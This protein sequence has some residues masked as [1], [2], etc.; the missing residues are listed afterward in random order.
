MGNL[1]RGEFYKLRKSKCFIG[2]ILLSICTG[3]LLIVE[4]EREWKEAYIGVNIVGSIS[5]AFMAII[6]GNFIFALLSGMFIINDFRRGSISKSFSFGY[7]RTKV[8]L[9]K[10]VVFIVFSLV[11]EVIYTTI[12]V[13]YVSYYYGFCE[14]LNLST[15]L[16]LL[17]VI[18]LGVIYNLATISIIAMIAIIT[19]NEFFTFIFPII[20]IMTFSLEFSSYKYLSYLLSY[21]PYLTGMRAINMFSSEAEIRRCIVSSF[22]TFIITFGGSVLFVN[23][24]DIK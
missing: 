6:F 15:I 23:H 3:V 21:L 22:A 2:M 1:I 24:E 4:W 12:F 11:L 20:L 14:T 9:S 8:I 13:I 16:Y 19:K 10:L 5:N 18:S 7:E 17:R